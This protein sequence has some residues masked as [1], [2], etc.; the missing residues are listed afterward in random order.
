MYISQ[1]KLRTIAIII[2]IFIIGFITGYFASSIMNTGLEDNNINDIK[3]K[4]IARHEIYLNLDDVF[5]CAKK[6]LKNN[7]KIAMVHRTDR[8]IDI[9]FSMKNNNIEPKRLQFIYPFVNTKSNLVLIEGT[10]NGSAG[11]IVEKNIIVHEEDGNYTDEINNI[12]NGGTK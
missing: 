5:K 3:I 10:K 8:L 12:F 6:L 1:E 9:I 7:G 11:L 4:A 2:I